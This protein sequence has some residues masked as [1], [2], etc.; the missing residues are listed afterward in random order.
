MYHESPDL[1]VLNIVEWEKE[2]FNQGLTFTG[3]QGK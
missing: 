2:H 1:G 3:A